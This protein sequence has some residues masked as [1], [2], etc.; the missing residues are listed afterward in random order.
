MSRKNIAT[1]I[2]ALPTTKLANCC[3]VLIY[4]IGNRH[5]RDTHANSHRQKPN[6]EDPDSRALAESLAL[7]CAAVHDGL[8]IR[9]GVKSAI[10][11]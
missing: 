7:C 3:E 11:N 2:V 8:K 9:A 5:A 4:Q 6:L 10:L 1:I